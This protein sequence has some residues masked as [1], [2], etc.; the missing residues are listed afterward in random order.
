VRGYDAG[1][2]VKGRKRP[3]LVD[4]QGFVLKV[5]VP[6]AQLS[7]SEGGQPLLEALG[8]TLPRLTHLWT[9]QGYKA[10]FVK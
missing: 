2:Q 9:D 3:I 8:N 4:T 1:K 5:L 10:S 6:S 7:D